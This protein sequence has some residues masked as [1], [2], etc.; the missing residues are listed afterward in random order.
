[1]VFKR[2]FCRIYIDRFQLVTF[3]LDESYVEQYVII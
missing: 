3:T 1:M 2:D